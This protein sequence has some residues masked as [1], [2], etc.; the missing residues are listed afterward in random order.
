MPSELGCSN[1]YVRYPFVEMSVRLARYEA[2]PVRGP[3]VG[4]HSG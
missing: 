4:M 1:V 2:L 3:G